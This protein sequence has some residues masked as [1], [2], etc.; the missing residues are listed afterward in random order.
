MARRSSMLGGMGCV[1]GRRINIML[2]R[3]SMEGANAQTLVVRVN[4]AVGSVRTK[5]IKKGSTEVLPLDVLL[6]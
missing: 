6:I 3:G 4:S 1:M 5:A 2:G